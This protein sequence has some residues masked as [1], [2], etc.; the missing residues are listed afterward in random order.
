MLKNL[1]QFDEFHINEARNHIAVVKKDRYSDEEGRDI[2]VGITIGSNTTFLPAVN[3][4]ELM[5]LKTEIEN[6]LKNIK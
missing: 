1:K 5:T 6:Y 2:L 4:N 3:T